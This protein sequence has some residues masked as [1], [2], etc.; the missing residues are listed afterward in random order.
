MW[1]LCSPRKP[2]V[3]FGDFFDVDVDQ[4]RHTID[5]LFATSF[6]PTG[7]YVRVLWHKST[8][9]VA[10]E[11]HRERYFVVIRHPNEG[12]R[13]FFK[14]NDNAAFDPDG[15][16]I[17]AMKYVTHD[18]IA[19]DVGLQNDDDERN[20]TVVL[21]FCRNLFASPGSAAEYRSVE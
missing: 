11:P 17:H 14:E 3:N 4:L 1:L 12:C 18:I 6:P 9:Y 20:A 21:L 13:Q 16:K 7:H 10:Y 8:A 2:S 19:V 5:A 15:H